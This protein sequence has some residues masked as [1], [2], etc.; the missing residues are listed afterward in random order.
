MSDLDDVI[1]SMK[2]EID[3]QVHFNECWD[4]TFFLTLDEVDEWL[5][6]IQAILNSEYMSSQKKLQSI[7]DSITGCVTI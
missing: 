4:E 6:E 2:A 7:I 3:C 5:G 1:N